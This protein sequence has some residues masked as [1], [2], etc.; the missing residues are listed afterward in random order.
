MKAMKQPFMNDSES[1]GPVMWEQVAALQEE[2][3][4]TARAM[5]AREGNAGSVHTTQLLNSALKKL[6]PKSRDWSE[7]SWEN[8]DA[9]FKDAFFMMRR[10]LIDYARRRKVRNEVKAGAFETEVVG[11]LVTAGAL[12]LDRL[13]DHAAANAELAEAVDRALAD[14][15]RLYPDLRLAEIVQHRCFE[16][17]TQVEIGKMLAESSDVVRKRERHAYGLLRDEL[18]SFFTGDESETGQP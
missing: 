2:L 1:D 12:N 4:R 15:D 5:L 13:V 16:G 10:V 8:R 3:K 14:L 18:K 11:S 7:V 9:F 6:A 17:L